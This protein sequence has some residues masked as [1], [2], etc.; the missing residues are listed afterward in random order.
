LTQYYYLVAS[1]PMLF[2]DGVPPFSSAAWLEMCR[3]QVTARDHALL[4]RISFA[5]LDRGSGDPEAWQAYSSWETA[6]RD[7]LA[8]QRAQRLGVSPDPFLREAPFYPGLPAMA[9]EA[10]AAG[11]PKA[12]ETALDRRRWS[13]L[14]ELEAGTQ[15]DLGRLVVYRLKLLLLERKNRFR[16]EPGR[17]AFAQEYTRVLDTAAAW[18]SADSPLLDTEKRND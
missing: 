15:F 16:I 5:A 3:E 7:E 14:E 13:C 8:V 9:K 17:E 12:V 11:T 2:F 4:S 18:M 6:L 1:L 10:L